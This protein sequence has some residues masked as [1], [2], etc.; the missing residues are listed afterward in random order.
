ME[1]ENVN[2]RTLY[3]T[4]KVNAMRICT[5]PHPPMI[6]RLVDRAEDYKFRGHISC[7]HTGSQFLF[8]LRT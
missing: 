2:E 8:Y 6:R 3:T 7:T 1:M 5:S 4:E